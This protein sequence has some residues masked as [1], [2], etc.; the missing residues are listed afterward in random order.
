MAGLPEF[1]DALF[2]LAEA[3]GDQRRDVF[4]RRRPAVADV[5]NLADLHKGEPARLSFPDEADPRTRLG[6]VIAV[7]RSGGGSRPS[8]S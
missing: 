1:G 8:A 4:T 3:L 7:A 2:H 6:G 5:E